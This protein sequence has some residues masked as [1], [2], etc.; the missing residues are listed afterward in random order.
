MEHYC[1]NCKGFFKPNKFDE[2]YGCCKK[3]SKPKRKRDRQV[4]HIF[5]ELSDVAVGDLMMCRDD[6]CIVTQVL[7][8]KGW[9]VYVPKSD[10][11]KLI[12]PYFT[13]TLETFS[14]RLR[15]YGSSSESDKN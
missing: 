2:F 3:C 15:R 13:D 8:N 11:T 14:L 7:P 9:T 4:W 1:T 10:S 5:S 6:V 12:C